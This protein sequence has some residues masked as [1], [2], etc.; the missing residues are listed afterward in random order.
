MPALGTIE[1]RACWCHEGRPAELV[2][3]LKYG[4]ATTAVTPLADAMA[5]LVPPVDMITWAPA[6]TERR[7]SRG[8]DQAELLARAVANR[9]G[10]K[11]RRLVRRGCDTPQTARDRAG[12]MAGPSLVPVGR[13]FQR[14][15]SVLVVD[16]VVTTG[17]TLR[18]MAVLLRKR[19]AGDVFGLVATQAVMREQGDAST[20]WYHP[21]CGKG[22]P[23]DLHHYRR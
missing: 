5:P 7:R 14:L 2:R 22:V 11:V 8:F 19:G 12:R 6:S 21:P 18:A 10:V 15:P 9:A 20:C 17:A 1:V 4:R 13:R 3:E 23:S 16:D